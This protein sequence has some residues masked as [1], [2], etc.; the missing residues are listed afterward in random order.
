MCAALEVQEKI[1]QIFDKNTHPG[2]LFR[3]V[4]GGTLTFQTAPGTTDFHRFGM[5]FLPMF[6][7]FGLIFS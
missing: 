7:K 2:V 4:Q 6:H 3:A 1:M 5:D